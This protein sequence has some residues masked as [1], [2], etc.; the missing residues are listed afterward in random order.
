[1]SGRPIILWDADLSEGHEW[2][3]VEI[4]GKYYNVEIE[5][6]KPE[7]IHIE[8]FNG[9]YYHGGFFMPDGKKIFGRECD[10]NEQTKAEFDKGVD[11]D[12]FNVEGENTIYI[13]NTD[14]I[15]KGD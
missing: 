7:I 15:T 9:K 4:N 2:L 13:L 12:S 14:N 10:F 11:G 1:M 8:R 5:E 6:S 3:N